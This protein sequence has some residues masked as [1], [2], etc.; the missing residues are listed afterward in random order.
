MRAPEPM[1]SL[2]RGELPLSDAFWTW[3]VLGA[4][5]VNLSTSIAF[6]LL[7]M[8][9]Q[10]V[11]ALIVGYAV[12]IP[13]NILALVGVWRSAAR[14]PGPALQADLARWLSL[15]LLAGLSVT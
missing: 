7:I 5:A 2:W 6:L 4:V 15:A 1:M 3:A 13:Y 11:A 9:E 14:H 10:P 12:S 8:A